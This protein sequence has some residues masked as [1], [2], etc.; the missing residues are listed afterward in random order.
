MSR[1]SPSFRE[2][3]PETIPYM[4]LYSKIMSENPVLR[5]ETVYPAYW[6]EEPVALT[7]AKKQYEMMQK[8]FSEESALREAQKYV[9]T[10]ENDAYENMIKVKRIM[11]DK[12]SRDSYLTDINISNEIAK[13]RGILKITPYDELPLGD[14]GEIDHFV[15]TKLLNWRE[16]ERERRMKDPV[17][18]W[19]FERLREQVFP[20]MFEDRLK[21]MTNKRDVYKKELMQAY[22]V[23][24]TGLV[25][26]SPFYYEDYMILFNKLR[27]RPHLARWN[28]RHRDNLAKWIIETLGFQ[29]IL[30]SQ[31][32]GLVQSYL[33]QLRSQYF[34]MIKYPADALSFNLPSPD[35]VKEIL[36][37]NG[38]GY[39]TEEGKLY[40]KRFYR[41]PALL[42]P[43]QTWTTQL[44]NDRSKLRYEVS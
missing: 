34:P 12:I 18:N 8:G 31:S 27:E 43:K 41:L 5:D 35:K 25:T 6:Q 37:A 16:V 26:Q 22:D 11:A 38:I 29:S 32:P 23:D 14:Q 15:Q 20:E 3:K 17:F 4:H 10:L 39:K 28:E 2:V 36:Y 13:W 21:S 1:S 40:I 19:Q 42:F 24:V 7:L 44:L 33:D 9:N 30:K